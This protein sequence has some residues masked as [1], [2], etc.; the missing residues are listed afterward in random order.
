[1]LLRKYRI[2]GLNLRSAAVGSEP[3]SAGCCGLER[4]L[5]GKMKIFEKLIEINLPSGCLSAALQQA[6]AN[7]VFMR[8]C[9][10]E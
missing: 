10:L 6:A 2:A 3:A 4:G 7:F 9:V 8:K 1:M 5:R